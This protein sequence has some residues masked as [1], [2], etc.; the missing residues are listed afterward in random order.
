[1]PNY[2]FTSQLPQ[3]LKNSPSIETI[4]VYVA[5]KGGQG[6]QAAYMDYYVTNGF[7]AR[8]QETALGKI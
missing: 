4:R 5:A 8:I 3:R 2:A 1:L 7:G 6:Y